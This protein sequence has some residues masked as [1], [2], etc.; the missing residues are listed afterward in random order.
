MFIRFSQHHDGWWHGFAMRLAINSHD[1]NNALP[2]KSPA[3][4]PEGIMVFLFK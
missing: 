2:E 4:A 1:I 3:S